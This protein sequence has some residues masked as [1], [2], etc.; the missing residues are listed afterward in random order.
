VGKKFVG[1]AMNLKTNQIICC[2][3]Y[4][5]RKERNSCS[6]L[7]KRYSLQGNALKVFRSKCILYL[8]KNILEIFKNLERLLEKK[9]KKIFKTKK[10]E[11]SQIK[12]SNIHHSISYIFDQRFLVF[13]FIPL[14]CRK[15]NVRNE[16]RIMQ[17]P[18]ISEE[19]SL[20]DIQSKFGSTTFMNMCIHV[21]NIFVKFQ[22][23]KIKKITHATIICSNFSSQTKKLL[24]FLDSYGSSG[25]EK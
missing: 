17:E 12:V 7:Q 16:V 22:Y 25:G 14:L 2:C 23:Q 24:Q 20:D 13:E 3:I 6:I 21:E 1:K 15:F 8:S 18:H 11:I 9:L 4:E 19:S 5:N 10:I